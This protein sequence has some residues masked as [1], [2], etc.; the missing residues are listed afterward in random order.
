MSDEEL[1]LPNIESKPE[2]IVRENLI[3]WFFN[4]FKYH[5]TNV[6]PFKLYFTYY[7]IDYTKKER[8]IILDHFNKS[9]WKYFYFPKINHILIV[10]KEYNF[11]RIKHFNSIVGNYDMELDEM[12]NYNPKEY[13]KEV[14]NETN[15]IREKIYPTLSEELIQETDRLKEIIKKL[16]MKVNELQT[17]IDLTPGSGREYKLAKSRFETKDYSE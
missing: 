1:V 14:Y 12:L 10:F 7:I 17:E 8:G 16:E 2:E 3:V 9:E 5:T 11:N 6:T 13:K 15:L 4:N